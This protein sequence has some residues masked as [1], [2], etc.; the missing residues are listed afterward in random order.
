MATE[1]ITMDSQ[2]MGISRY[3]NKTSLRPI[4]CS[5]TKYPF[6]KVVIRSRA[7]K[8]LLT[9]SNHP[10]R[11]ANEE[12]RSKVIQIFVIFSIILPT[13]EYKVME[14][15]QSII[16]QPYANKMPQIRALYV[17]FVYKAQL[18]Y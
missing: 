12:K 1:S 7:T 16:N 8:K 5:I 3:F 11:K 9:L 15:K 2:A 10:K 14:I 4:K 18:L 13:L 6:K 17:P